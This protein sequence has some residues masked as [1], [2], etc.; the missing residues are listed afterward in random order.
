MAIECELFDIEQ[1]PSDFKVC[2]GCG[3]I[4]RYENESCVDSECGS[5]SFLSDEKSVEAAVT[6]EYDFWCREEGFDVLEADKIKMEV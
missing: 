3:K 1:K 4:N 6:K 5:A 2:T